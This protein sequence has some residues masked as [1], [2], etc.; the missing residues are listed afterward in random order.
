[1]FLAAVTQLSRFMCCDMLGPTL[2]MLALAF[3]RRNMHCHHAAHC[4]GWC[5]CARHV[6]DVGFF[7]MLL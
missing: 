3:G 2:R 5:I 6:S 7:T 1:L 4:R